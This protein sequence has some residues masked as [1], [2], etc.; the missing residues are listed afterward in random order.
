LDTAL[1]AGAIIQMIYPDKDFSRIAI[2]IFVF[3][4]SSS[5]LNA[6]RVADTAVGTSFATST[7]FIARNKFETNTALNQRNAAIA[8]L[9]ALIACQTKIPRSNHFTAL[10]TPETTVNVLPQSS[11]VRHFS[12]F[13]G[14]VC[15]FKL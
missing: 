7:K 15:A 3:H 10:V 8:V 12:S 5:Y 4:G 1:F 9:F 11:F 13:L 2:Q 14:Y 6:L